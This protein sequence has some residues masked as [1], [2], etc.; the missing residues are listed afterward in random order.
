VSDRTARQPGSRAEQLRQ[1]RQPSRVP[2]VPTKKETPLADRRPVTNAFGRSVVPPEQQNLRNAAVVTSRA[3][4]F[5]NPIRQGVSTP[6]RRKVYRVGANGVETRLPSLPMLRFSWQW[7][8]G[9]LTVVLLTFVILMLA[10]PTFKVNQVEVLGV[11]RVTPAEV[12]AVVQA[13]S[14]SIFT[15]DRAKILNALGVAFPELAD[16]NLKVTSS[17]V[18]QVSARERQPVLAWTA[19]GQTIWVDADG[20]TMPARGDAGALLTIQS[21]NSAPLAKPVQLTR[22]ATELLMVILDRAEHP[23]TPQDVINNINPA[24]M[25]AA[26]D[27]SALMPT[28]A[29]LVYD[30]ISG[31]GWQ[32]TRGWKV[33]FGLSLENIQFKQTEYAA[34]VEALTA[35]GITPSMI[36]VEHIDSPH[37]RTD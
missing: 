21:E 4:P 23:V 34:I 1:K 6:V 28:G 7:V 13:N 15:L 12:Q 11:N 36:S 22:N 27:L 2:V 9:F 10:L 17:A 14:G 24:V 25:K 31:M 30:S 16:L 26:I 18:V 29:V 35:Q 32:D 5:N 8:S 20:V 3:T 19:G 33:Y 37:F